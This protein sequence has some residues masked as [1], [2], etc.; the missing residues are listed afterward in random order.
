MSAII[1][2]LKN[3]SA[4]SSRLKQLQPLLKQITECL[5]QELSE[6]TG[7]MFDSA[8]D[9]LFQMAENANS[10]ELQNEYFDTMRML[11]VE[12]KP[13]IQA[14]ADGL[15]TRLQPAQ[16][17]TETG[18]FDEDELSL[19]DQSEMEELV[20]I[21]TM[22][23]RAMNLYGEAVNHLEARIE[24]LALKSPGIFGKDALS[25]KS[26]CESFRDALA[27]I[28]LG[29]HTKLVLFKLFDQEVIQHLAP[30]YQKLNQLFVDQG[31]LPQIKTAN[32]AHPP[33][34]RYSAQAEP[35]PGSD[36]NYAVFRD[37]MVCQPSAT[38]NYA[39]S[40]N[41]GYG[42]GQSNVQSS[43]II[44]GHGAPMGTPSMNGGNGPAG[45]G[46]GAGDH[47][48]QEINRVASQ[49]IYG[50]NTA[51]NGASRAG[52]TNQF[53]DRRDV[54]QALSSI[55]QQALDHSQ[56][57]NAQPVL[58]NSAELKQ[59]LLSQI[60][61]QS[62]GT[63]SRQVSRVDEKTIDFIE[64]LFDAIIADEAISEPVTN[65]LL[66]L[67]IPLIK[68]AMIDEN[69]FG[70]SE[71]PCK[72]TLNM[73]AYLGRGIAE[74]SDPLF[75]KLEQVVESILNEF[76][77]DLES[78]ENAVALLEEIEQDEISR[79]VEIETET[80]K[81]V[82]HAHARDMV[83][84]ELQKHARNQK[85]PKAS[86]KLILKHWSTLMFHRYIK[87]GKQSEQW[88]QASSV[89]RQLIQLLQPI[90]SSQSHFRLQSE[91]D[92]VLDFIHNSLLQ[93][94]QNPVEI[95]TEINQVYTLLESMLEQSNFSDRALNQSSDS[96]LLSDS[97]Y[98][99]VTGEIDSE[100]E[101]DAM[102]DPALDFE[103]EID[104][105]QEQARLA[106]EKVASLPSEIRPGVWFKVFNGEDNAARRVKLSLIV[107]EEAKLVFVDRMGVKVIEKDAEEFLN[108]INTEQSSLIADHSAFDHALGMVINS[109][110]AAN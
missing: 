64:M 20:A 47:L 55:Q 88:Q 17:E 108:E 16:T 94:R 44:A 40:H 66:R 100:A 90:A 50:G 4:S 11:R 28:E 107:M 3:T 89:A 1:H 43:G 62:A 32:S 76:D 91:K 5:N 36:T 92:E 57:G 65:L 41:P 26:L 56:A 30:L 70:A 51:S 46:T 99:E 39:A 27:D 102:P 80:Q 95:E 13:V 97:Y 38:A 24:H 8:D 7:C 49:F 45:S 12:R 37:N 103:D 101:L 104:P 83:L 53:Y 29:A 25:P 59:A 96:T 81:A 109:L 73:L 69:F 23:S 86:Q 106:R 52:H 31:I 82:L 48:Q 35:A 93:T 58:I 61:Q 34:N 10:N 105:L 85:L 21:S 79:S 19:V 9:M 68:V 42:S 78:F 75:E 71:H 74:R 54:M 22:Q 2:R 87:H 60:S 77:I 84:A 14:F 6:L 33:K 98:T 18:S 110:S 72:T 63:I 15:R 67:Q